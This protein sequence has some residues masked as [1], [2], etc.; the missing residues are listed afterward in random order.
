MNKSKTQKGCP[1]GSPGK[2]GKSDV[3]ST[4]PDSRYCRLFDPTERLR[5]G[6][7]VSKKEWDELNRRI[8][9]LEAKIHDQQ[10]LLLLHIQD[11]EESV[12]ELKQI[13][14]EIKECHNG[15]QQNL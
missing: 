8:A 9:D 14:N 13:F 4:L 15:V 12:T 3:E 6:A 7:W 2:E 10:N 1:T 11:H 5:R